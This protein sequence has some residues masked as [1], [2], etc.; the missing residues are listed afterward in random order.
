M[1]MDIGV[2]CFAVFLPETK[3]QAFVPAPQR[4]ADFLAEVQAAIA[5][6]LSLEDT[7]AEVQLPDF[8]GYALIGWVHPNT[9]VPAA[10]IDLK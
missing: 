5:Q 2:D 1:T 4:M 3:H 9:N 10:Y 8:Q 7:V 6:G